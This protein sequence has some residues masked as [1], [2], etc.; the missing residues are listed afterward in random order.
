[1][2]RLRQQILDFILAYHAEHGNT[3]TVRTIGAAFDRCPSNIHYHV[4]KLAAEGHL[5]LPYRRRMELGAERSANTRSTF[6][7]QQHGKSTDSDL[8]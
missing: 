2:S 6:L 1:M 7:A 8:Y 3:P 4:H 5:R